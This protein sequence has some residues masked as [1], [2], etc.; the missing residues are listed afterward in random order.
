MSQSN[1]INLIAEE[2]L[3]EGDCHSPFLCWSQG[4]EQ[5]AW[6]GQPK[7]RWP[8]SAIG[9]WWMLPQYMAPIWLCVWPAEEGFARWSEENPECLVVPHLP[10][11]HLCC[12]ASTQC[13]KQKLPSSTQLV[14]LPWKNNR[15]CDAAWWNRK[16]WSEANKCFLV[17]WRDA[18][19]SP[20]IK[21]K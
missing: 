7:N 3:G 19:V 6:T 14:S 20:D 15:Q 9:N 18:Y 12:T 16:L 8:P 11:S 17:K 10:C 21:W 1:K 4:H 2:S 5:V 13:H